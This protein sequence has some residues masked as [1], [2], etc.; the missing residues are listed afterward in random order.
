MTPLDP[1]VTAQATAWTDAF[2]A[3]RDRLRRRRR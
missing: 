2:R 1:T 3:L